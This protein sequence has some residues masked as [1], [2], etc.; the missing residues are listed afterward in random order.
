MC[1]C[2]PSRIADHAP[3]LACLVVVGSVVCAGLPAEA[4]RAACFG[5]GLFLQ[6]AGPPGERGESDAAASV[7]A[8]PV[9]LHAHGESGERNGGWG[10]GALALAGFRTSGVIGSS[11]RATPARPTL[12]ILTPADQAKIPAGT[13]RVRGV[14]GANGAKVRIVVNGVRASVREGTF[15][16]DVPVSVNTLLLTAVATTARG[17]IASHQ[18]GLAV[19]GTAEAA[20]QP[21]PFSANGVPPKHV[22]FFDR[23]VPIPAARTGN[24]DDDVESDPT[25]SCAEDRGVDSP[26]VVRDS[27]LATTAAGTTETAATTHD[28]DPVAA[29][30]RL[31]W[32]SRSLTVEPRRET[33]DRTVKVLL[34]PSGGGLRAESALVTDRGFLTQIAADMASLRLAGNRPGTAGPSLHAMRPGSEYSFVVVFVFGADGLWRVW[35]F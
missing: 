23:S 4:T 12:T 22:A 17:A 5:R 30:D 7:L 16:A 18:I 27:T 31:P 32:R 2:R 34:V 20:L 19:S 29:A 1:R 13:L 26:F 24:V 33:V 6:V 8:A 35:W 3:L 25:I 15:M 9:R 14:V 10:S 21:R 28:P 11:R